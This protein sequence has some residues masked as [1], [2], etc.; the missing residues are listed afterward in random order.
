MNPILFPGGESQESQ[1]AYLETL[2]QQWRENNAC[3]HVKVIDTDMDDKIIAFACWQIFVGDDV[4]FIKT[5]PEEQQNTP[6]LNEAAGREF[7]GG[8]LKMR[9]RILGKNPHC[10]RFC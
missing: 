8:L 7:F 3:R 4:K 9:V 2:L 5:D 1:D 10:R 6:G